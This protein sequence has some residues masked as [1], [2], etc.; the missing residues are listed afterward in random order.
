MSGRQRLWCK[1]GD[2]AKTAEIAGE[3][4][5]PAF[6]GSTPK[7]PKIPARPGFI[8]GRHVLSVNDLTTE[9]IRALFR[10]DARHQDGA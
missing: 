1:R 7:M 9:E 8:K 2:D 5:R 6:I 4:V 3:P 10:S